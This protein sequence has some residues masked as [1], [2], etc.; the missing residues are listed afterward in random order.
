[1]EVTGEAMTRLESSDDQVEAE[2]ALLSEVT[3]PEGMEATIFAMAPAVNYPVF[4]AAAPDGTL[5]VSSDK[6]G[7]LDRGPRRG[8]VLR[9]RDVDSDG[10][11]DEVKM[12]VADV[13]SPRGL[14]WDRD[15]LY[16]MHPP[17]LSAFIDHDGDGISDEQKVLVKNI[18][19]GFKDRPADHTSNGV[20]LGVDGWLYCAINSSGARSSNFGSVSGV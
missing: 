8:R 7:S 15:R 14:V 10:R 9:V 20:E 2:K 19:F 16:L 6:N 3:V 13:D 17:H 11:A 12:F 1:M 4:V 18:A 5:Y